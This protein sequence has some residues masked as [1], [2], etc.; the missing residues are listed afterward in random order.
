[1]L[2]TC[3]QLAAGLGAV[4]KGAAKGKPVSSRGGVSQSQSQSQSSLQ[5]KPVSKGKPVS[6]T[7][8]AGGQSMSR[9][10]GSSGSSAG[11][12]VGVGHAPLRL[13]VGERFVELFRREGDEERARKREGV[14]VELGRVVEGIE[15]W[16]REVVDGASNRS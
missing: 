5:G 13:W 6:G 3:E 1:M 14:N 4:E 12:N 11:V 9:G 8:Q 15:Q 2:R 16:G 7:G 10:V